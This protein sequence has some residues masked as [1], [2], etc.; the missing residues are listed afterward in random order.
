M[1]LEI[2]INTGDFGWE[3]EIHWSKKIILTFSRSCFETTENLSI[4]SYI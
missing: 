3:G 2:V 1:Y 4:I